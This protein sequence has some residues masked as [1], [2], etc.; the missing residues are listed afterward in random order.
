MTGHPGPQLEDEAVRLT[1]LHNPCSPGPC[2]KAFLNEDGDVIYQGC[3]VGDAHGAAAPPPGENWVLVPRDV[4]VE[5]ARR[6][7]ESLE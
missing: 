5:A 4:A 1:D 6:L 3:E 2:P 7:L